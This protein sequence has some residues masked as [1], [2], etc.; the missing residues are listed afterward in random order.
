MNDYNKE[1]R[2][3]AVMLL[4]DIGDND[5]LW[6]IAEHDKDDD[7]RLLAISFITDQNILSKLLGSVDSSEV[8]NKIIERLEDKRVLVNQLLSSRNLKRNRIVVNRLIT[9]DA[10]R[11]L[12]R[13]LPQTT[14][15]ISTMIQSFLNSR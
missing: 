15:A 12:K 11:I 9:L 13:I 14:G 3:Y 8:F 4:K 2:R 7:I 6:T 10:S 5:T 1:V